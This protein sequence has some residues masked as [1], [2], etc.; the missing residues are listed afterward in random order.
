MT[1]FSLV[2]A[3][4]LM[5]FGRLGDMFG[6]YP[7]FIGGL[8]WLLIWSI[9]TGFSTS[10]I[11]L[12][13]CR[14]LQGLGAAAALP[15]GIQ[16]M[17]S[18]YRPSQR[19]NLVFAVYGTSAVVGFY[20][21]M[22]FAGLIGQYTRWGYYFWVGAIM[23][24]ITLASSLYAIQ[25]DQAQKVEGRPQMDYLGAITVVIGLVLLVFSITQSAHATA[26]RR[27]PYIIVCFILAVI[28]LSAAVYVEARV[29]SHPLLPASI[30]HTRSMTPL[31]FALLLLFGSWG[32]FSVYGTFILEGFILH[33]VPARLLLGISG[34]GA[35]GSQLLLAFIPGA[36]AN[37]WARVFPATILSTI[38]IDL[39]VILMTVF[40][41]TTFPSAQQGLAGGVL[42]SVLQLGVA[43]TLGLT[44]IVQSATVDQV[45]LARSYKDT[46]WFG[47]GVSGI[48]LIL[49][50]V[51]GKIP[52]ATSELTPEERAELVQVAEDELQDDVVQSDAQASRIDRID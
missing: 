43:L 31:L 27:T 41:T 7:V 18:T 26:G 49:M 42:N 47:V 9:I 46:F 36:N 25:P 15:T 33:L 12:N 48:G 39:S 13:V 19:K 6:G 38:G 5:V 17:G 16:I 10:S 52:K 50:L 4:T 22:F 2:I 29:A 34:L 40:I 20:G 21:G 28:S 32:I 23:I 8:A 45:G 37:Y 1:A 44:D 11:M 14:A 51:W 35:L 3:S 24:G 30:F